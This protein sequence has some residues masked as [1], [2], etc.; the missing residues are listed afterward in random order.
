MTLPQG[1]YESDEDTLDAAIRGFQ[2]VTGFTAS[3]PFLELGSI[4]QKSGKF[5][6]GWAFE[7]ACDPAELVS[8]TCE[9]EWP[10]H[11]CATHSDS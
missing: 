1:E 11:F 3:E 6:A 8:N 2:E 7:G 4:R 10:P 5:V 9:V